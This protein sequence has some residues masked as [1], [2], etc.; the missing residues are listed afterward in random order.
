MTASSEATKGLPWTPDFEI[1][2]VSHA[3]VDA[4]VEDDAV[5]VR[6]DDGRTSAHH[7]FFLR[8]NSPDPATVHPLSRELVISPLAIP[9][10]IK[11]VAASVDESGALAVVWSHDGH[12]SRFH[13]GW[14]RAHA[15]LDDEHHEPASPRLWSS[16]DLDAPPTFDGPA[17][18]NDDRTFLAWL[19]AL[20][21]VGLAR[22]EGLPLRDGLLEDVVTRVGT[23]RETNFGRVYH[24][25]AKEDPDSNAYT[26][27]ELG[28]HMDI[29]T[30]ECPPGLQFLYCRV[31]S[32]AGG[33]GVYADGYRI[34]EDLRVEEPAHFDA[35]TRINWE[36]KNRAKDCDYRAR[37][38]IIKLDEDG[39][40]TEIRFNPFLRAPL[41]APREVQARAYRSVRAMV[42][43]AESPRYKLVFPYRPGDLLAFDNR[44]VLHGRAAYDTAG[45][46]RFFE[47]M[48]ADRD[49]LY[50]RIRFLR[51]R[52]LAY[53][54][55]E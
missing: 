42:R 17:A 45:G 40:I 8:E 29:P 12:V 34:A 5:S 20:R 4:E 47:G 31:N 37:G 39:N 16:A 28:Q 53:A 26:S 2:P 54:Q 49:D 14:L 22:L 10:D 35:L 21:D 32:V 9:G 13:P 41:R 25:L 52:K 33:E 23:V 3:I 6:W 11:P 51:D 19:E 55:N 36:Y 27:V 50:S 15:W 38:P 46:D 30:R 24:L 44:R 18:L 1:Y 48:Y 43:R 7:A